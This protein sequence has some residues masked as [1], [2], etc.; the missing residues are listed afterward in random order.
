VLREVV[1]DDDTRLVD[2]LHVEPAHDTKSDAVELCV[3]LVEDERVA[4][5]VHRNMHLRRVDERDCS[6]RCVRCCDDSA[7]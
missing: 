1:D 4:V 5:N 7:T 2:D 3:T 6:N